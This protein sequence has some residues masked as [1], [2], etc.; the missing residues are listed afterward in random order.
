VRGLFCASS[1]HLISSLAYGRQTEFGSTLLLLYLH[2][3]N[4]Y[5][6]EP[7]YVSEYNL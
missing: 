4:V 1:S 6:R 7:V 5:K 2:V 3:A